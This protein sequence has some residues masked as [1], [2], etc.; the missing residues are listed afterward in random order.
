MQV[1]VDAALF[2]SPL[3]GILKRL[4]ASGDV[5]SGA[6]GGPLVVGTLTPQRNAMTLAAKDSTS[7]FAGVYRQVFA[8]GFLKGWRGGSIPCLAAVPQFTAI[9]PVYLLAE[10]RIGNPVVSMFMASL[11]ESLF[12]FS[13]HRRNAQIQYNAT[14]PVSQHVP[15]QSIYR[16]MG[17]GF[18]PHVFRNCFAQMGIRLFSPHS[19]EVVCRLPGISTLS[20]G[21]RLVASDF[22]C[23]VLAATLSLPFNHAFSWAAC[24]PELEQMSYARRGMAMVQWLIGTYREQGVKLLARD[25]G[26]RINYTAFLFTGYRLVERTLVDLSH[27]A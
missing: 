7:S 18:V 16:L 26:I 11:F 24:T 6:I 9:G 5:L 21:K 20:E 3:D 2:S 17:A 12:T 1:T 22:A 13:A 19:Y 23:S 14:V 8:S 10:K 25:V 15:C 4:Q 27:D